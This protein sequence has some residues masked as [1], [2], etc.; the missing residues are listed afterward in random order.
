MKEAIISRGRAGYP[1]LYCPSDQEVALSKEIK[2]AAQELKRDWY[3]WTCTSGLFDVED[4]QIDPQ[5]TIHPV[6][7]LQRIKDQVMP[8]GAF[9]AV[10]TLFDFRPHILNNTVNRHI[11]DL[12][13][14]LKTSRST[15]VMAGPDLVFP[16]ELRREA[17]TVELEMPSDETLGQILERIKSKQVKALKDKERTDII[18]AARG[19]TAT[20]AENAFALAASQRDL[21][22][23]NIWKNK[24]QV[25]SR[26]E[27]QFVENTVKL[28]DIGGLD[29]L[30]AWLLKRR[31]ATTKKARE[32]G[33][34]FPRGIVLVGPPGTAKSMIAKAVGDVYDCPTM[35]LSMGACMNEL[36]G[37]SE[38]ILR[39]A[40]YRAEA[41]APVVLWLDEIEKMFSG[42]KSSGR[43][44]AGLFRRMFAEFLTWLSDRTS[45]VFVVATANQVHDLPPELTRCQ[46]FDQIFEVGL[47]NF[48]ERCAITAI[49]TAK[50]KNVEVSDDDIQEVASKS[51]GYSGAEIE[52]SIEEAMFEGFEDDCRK[53]NAGD[54]ISCLKL[55]HPTSEVYRE[56][57]KEMKQWAQYRCRP[58]SSKETRDRERQ[59]E[60]GPV[61]AR[62][63]LN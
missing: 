39:E 26:E 31:S 12:I 49:H 32:Y 4:R 18:R 17:V 41:I 2:A 35:R 25:I 55:Q 30:K 40:I 58:A 37:R 45:H 20:E 54:I 33:L 7:A 56:E 9:P 21:T 46:R 11:R 63:A 38:R 5:K 28:D 6:V 15:L 10:Y 24:A 44:D 3:G 59:V 53:T 42:A 61:G 16:P 27:L 8:A 60:D 62:E 34:R 22:P 1:L 51:E 47:P 43:S 23:R 14:Y 57:I 52:G 19:L 48:A 36:I 50:R 29:L 13:P